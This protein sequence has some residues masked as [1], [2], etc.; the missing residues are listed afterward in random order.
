MGLTD[1]KLR[2]LKPP[3]RPKKIFD[4]DGLYIELRPNGGM[5]WRFKYRFDGKE[6]SL[7]FG[8]YPEVPLA[9]ARARRLEARMLV[10]AGTDP[11]AVRK[12]AKQARQRA[13]ASTLEAVSRAWL[14]RR[15]SAWTPGTREAIAASL[16]NHVFPALGAGRS[17]RSLRWTSGPWCRRLTIRAPE[18][19]PDECSSGYARSTATRCRRNWSSLIPRTRSSHPRSSD[20]EPSAID[21]HFL[22][23]TCR[24]SFASSMFTRAT[25]PRRRHSSC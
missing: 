5:W 21:S 6:K 11:S 19:R 7:S 20:P 9:L 12:Q 15:A 16:E 14:S 8:T 24:R 1:A 4:G 13:A 3:E 22:P 25:R 18:R 17:R 2:N 10:A 23:R